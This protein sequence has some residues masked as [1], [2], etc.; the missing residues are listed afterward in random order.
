MVQGIEKA[1]ETGTREREER[2]SADFQFLT[3]VLLVPLVDRLV[4]KMNER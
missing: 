3:V 2:V 4:E 1:Q